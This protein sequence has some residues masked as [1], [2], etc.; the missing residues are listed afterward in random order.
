VATRVRPSGAQIE[1]QHGDQQVVVVEVGGALRSY[2]AG[3]RDV[4]DGYGEWEMATAGRGQPLIPWPNRLRDGSYEFDGVRYQ[5]PLSEPATHNAIHGLVRWSNWTVAERGPASLRM[6]HVL[7]PQTGYPFALA[8][9]IEYALGPS[10]LAVRT[11]ATNVGD[12]PCPYGA[13]AHPYLS[14]G[15][16][17]VDACVLQAPGTRWLRTDDRSLP[18]GA[19]PVDGTEYDFRSPRQ[20]GAAKLD[21]GFCALQRDDDG[22]ARVR[23]SAPDGATSV[24]LWQDES[25]DYLMLFTGDTVP[26]TDRRRRGLAV[27]PMTCAPNAY[28][29]GDGLR[30]LQPGETLIGAWGID[31]FPSD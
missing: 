30:T 8:L 29:S 5:L 27:E 12:Q 14:A 23:L 1:L 28:Q 22:L 7:H 4:L 15:N 13:G 18:V 16:G 21:T 6:E 9:A 17:L 19:E 24:T 25:Y 2:R 31:P 20:V 11:S 3:D 10:G 26:D